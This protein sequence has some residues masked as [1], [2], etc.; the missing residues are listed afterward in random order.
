VARRFETSNNDHVH[1]GDILS[2][3]ERDFSVHVRVRPESSTNSG[4]IVSQWGSNN[5]FGLRRD[6]GSPLEYTFFINAAGGGNQFTTSGSEVDE[7]T[8]AS[9]V[10]TFDDS[11]SDGSC[12]GTLY[13]DN[14]SVGSSS[15][16]DRINATTATVSLG[17]RADL[18]R[19]FEG[20]IAEFAIW[21]DHILTDQQRQ[22]LA[23]GVSPL[24]IHPLPD[25][26][27][28]LEGGTFRD[29]IGGVAGTDVSGTTAF[30]HPPVFKPA[31]PKIAPATGDTSVLTLL[32]RG[33][34]KPVRSPDGN[35]YAI[36]R[37]SAN[38]EKLACVKS[39]NPGTV[40][41]TEQDS[42]NAPA[43]D[44]FNIICWH[45]DVTG[46]FINVV[47]QRI[48]ESGVDTTESVM[49]AKFDMANDAWVDLGTSD[50]DIVVAT[51]NAAGAVSC[52]IV[53]QYDQ[54]AVFFQDDFQLVS[55]APRLRVGYATSTDG[56]ENWTDRGYL[57]GDA[58]GAWNQTQPRAVAGDAGRVHIAWVSTEGGGTNIWSVT[59]LNDFTLGTPVDTTYNTN[60]AY[61]IGWPDYLFDGGN[62]A[63]WPYNNGSDDLHTLLLTSED[64]PIAGDFSST[65]ITTTD[66][67]FQDTGTSQP[68]VSLG[69]DGL[70]MTAVVVSDADRDID[71]YID[72]GSGTWSFVTT[73]LAG[74]FVHASHMVY[75]HNGPKIGLIYSAGTAESYT[76]V[77]RA[78]TYTGLSDTTDLGWNAWNNGPFLY[79][80]NLYAMLN[81]NQRSRLLMMKSDGLTPG[82]TDWDLQDHEIHMPVNDRHQQPYVADAGNNTN[83]LR[84]GWAI[85]VGDTIECYNALECGNLLLSVF[86]LATDAWTTI[87]EEIVNP[88]DNYV[89]WGA[90]SRGC[91]KAGYDDVN[92]HRL[93]AAN[94]NE[95]QDFANG[96]YRVRIFR[97]PSAGSWT[98]LGLGSDDTASTQYFIG[99]LIGPD[100][101]GGFTL[102]FNDHT[103]NS[104]RGMYI[105]D[106]GTINAS[107]SIDSSVDTPP[108]I[109]GKGC[110]DGDT[111][112]CPYVD[113]G[114]DVSIASWTAGAAPTISIDTAVIGAAVYRNSQ[115][116]VPSPANMFGTYV[117]N[118]DVR[119]YYVL[120]SDQ[121][122]YID[123]VSGAVVS[124]VTVTEMLSAHNVGSSVGIGILYDDAG[125]VKFASYQAVT[126]TT[127]VNGGL[128]N[129]GLVNRGL[130]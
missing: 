12:T 121:D 71:F 26:Y 100:T 96:D 9:L 30:P 4:Y 8:W 129:A 14:A 74:T 92:G 42:T 70:V 55:A 65:A 88:F 76:G 29:V 49:F 18:A 21:V 114:N 130:M 64:D 51:P 34:S 58:S 80:G 33:Y 122:I 2:L 59:M 37:A 31:G 90:V 16:M 35:Y 127:L 119:L 104:L 32:P 61:G 62:V 101:L 109:V 94:Y 110:M 7:D 56:G 93:V 82:D 22:M 20:A 40:A 28:S 108:L 68:L 91:I 17:N 38:A 3:E 47:Y 124:G 126:V 86:D 5:G 24:M 83:G 79:G 53:A 89:N 15:S 115:S 128:V 63:Y 111:V 41:F 81:N 25:F 52:C 75:E 39:T 27:D 106:D 46:D 77:S 60:D 118:G 78:A 85:R 43:S 48:R 125:S 84:G 113:A 123:N 23:D 97:K 72:N 54:L 1:Y 10:L 45:Y 103:N 99:D 87:L 73:L 112:Y 102:I 57:D 66:Q 120:A 98:N 19:D 11:G 69:V 36:G 107:F 50:Y 67:A 13:E 6:G 116:T 44:N 117:F 95:T 105:E